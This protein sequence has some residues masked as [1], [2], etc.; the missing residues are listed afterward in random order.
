[1]E[2]G[3]FQMRFKESSFGLGT[4]TDT[5]SGLK[6]P[7]FP[8]ASI[9]AALHQKH[10]DYFS[11]DVEGKELEILKTIPFD[12]LQIDTLSVE[13]IHGPAGKSAYKAFMEQHG[14]VTHKE[15]HYHDRRIDLYVDDLIFVNKTLL[16]PH[17]L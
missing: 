11:L 9:L 14:Y 2:T 5:A 17:K 13:Y 7:C 6:V 12:Q 15:I 4:L 10:V 3:I 8:L 16:E 1:M